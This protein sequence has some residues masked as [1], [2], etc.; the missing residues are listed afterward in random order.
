MEIGIWAEEYY[1]AN[2][3]RLYSRPSGSRYLVNNSSEI[4]T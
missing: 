2:T 3:Q 1:M 4:N